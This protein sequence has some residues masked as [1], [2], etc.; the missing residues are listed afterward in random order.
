M[1]N[2]FHVSFLHIY[3]P[4]G[5]HWGTPNTI[6]IG[7][8]Q[9]YKIERIMYYKKT[10]GRVVYQIRW[11]GYDAIENTWLGEE[12]LVNASDLLQTLQFRHGI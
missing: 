9:K 2:I 11:R 1:H 5:T 10:G 8:N 6:F 4:G 7:D 3:L 12:D